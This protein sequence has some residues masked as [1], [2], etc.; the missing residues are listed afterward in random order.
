MIRHPPRTTRSDP[1]FPYRTPVRATEHEALRL[2]VGEVPPG[3]RSPRPNRHPL[4]ELDAG[5]GSD[6]EQLPERPLLGVLGAGRIAGCRT[7]AAILLRDQVLVR[8]ALPPV[9]ARV[10]PELGPNPL[11]QSFREC[12]AGQ[13]GTGREPACRILVASVLA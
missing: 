10:A 8:Q 7:D 9:L 3:D 12:R 4:C 5:V 13:V 2:R 11:V 1:L 6:I